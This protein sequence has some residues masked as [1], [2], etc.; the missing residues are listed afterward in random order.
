MSQV[1]EWK[2]P[3]RLT[4]SVK[5]KKQLREEGWER[6]YG[7]RDVAQAAAGRF[8][9]SMRQTQGRWAGAV[10]VLG[11]DSPSGRA[12]RFGTGIAHAAVLAG[13]V[14][15]QGAGTEPPQAG[16]AALGAL[17]RPS[18]PIPKNGRGRNGKRTE[19]R[20]RPEGEKRSGEP[21]PLH[22]GEASG[23]RKRADRRRTLLRAE[24]GDD[25]RAAPPK[26]AGAPE[27]RQHPPGPIP[28]A[29]APGLSAFYSRSGLLE[30]STAL[31]A[32]GPSPAGGGGG[33]AEGEESGRHSPASRPP[34]PAAWSC[35][36]R[37]RS[38]AS[39]A[40]PAPAAAAAAR[41]PAGRSGGTGTAAF[42]S[43]CLS[44]LA[45]RH[46]LP[47]CLLSLSPLF[48]FLLFPE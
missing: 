6:N 27:S 23:R 7:L 2:D 40:A 38:P 1:Y 16:A 35:S 32:S 33:G 18:R 31:T 29:P 28:T 25:G 46:T 44:Q 43:R 36:G 4:V 41:D 42:S 26:T 10:G 14:D 45:P 9:P 8:K 13:P 17:P 11:R 19:E 21:S 47:P 48:F 39:P 37:A 20:R 34:L 5:R 30:A 22:R 15:V 3:I 24:A 12:R